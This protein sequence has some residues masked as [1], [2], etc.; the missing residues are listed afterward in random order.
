MF[1][2]R[3]YHTKFTCSIQT[4]KHFQTLFK[5]TQNRKK[6]CLRVKFCEYQTKIDDSSQSLV[7]HLLGKEYYIPIKDFI[8]P[9]LKTKAST[10]DVN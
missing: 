8:D 6:H 1:K 3:L 10:K 9:K 5:M 7:E 2:C 4:N